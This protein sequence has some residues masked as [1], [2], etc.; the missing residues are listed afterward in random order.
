MKHAHFFLKPLVMASI[1]AFLCHQAYAS[2]FEQ[3]KAEWPRTDFS[4]TSIDLTEILSGGPGKEGIPAIDKPDFVE[5][6]FIHD[7]LKDFSENEPVIGVVI[8]GQAKAYPL[9]I[10]M[11]HEIVNDELGGVP[12]SVTYCPLCNTSIVFDRRVKGQLLDFGTTGKLRHSDMIMYDRQTE[13]WWQ[14]YSGEAVVGQLIGTQ[15]TIL[16]SRLESLKAFKDRAP[17]GLIQVPSQPGIRNYGANPYIGY[18]TS[19]TPFLYK[20]DLPKGIPPMMRVVAVG[21]QAVMLPTLME[22][23]TF[24][25]GDLVFSWSPGQS[26]ALDAPNIANGR[27]VGNVRVTKNG[28]DIP[29]VVTFAFAFYAFN[30]DATILS[31]FSKAK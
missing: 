16:P 20:G 5:V 10:L 24:T 3:W 30:P 6:K 9:R 1:L 17:K 15:L 25:H 13:S 8:A 7:Y 19:R 4:K 21:N 18:D 31:L 14:Q 26:S 2:V 22:E 29:Y 28:K 12:I 23:K 27:D 11:W